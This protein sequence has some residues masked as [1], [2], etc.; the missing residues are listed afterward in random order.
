M[1]SASVQAIQIAATGMIVIIALWVLG[2]LA[3]G[4]VGYNRWA[5]RDS[6]DAT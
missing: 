1:N 4:W 3:L 2:A 6:L 5:G